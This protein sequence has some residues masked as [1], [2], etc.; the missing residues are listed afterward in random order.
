ML[1]FSDS[2]TEG[3]LIEGLR[4]GDEHVFETLVRTYGGRLLSVAR[5]MLNNEED[6]RDADRKSVV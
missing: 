5:R 2:M 1:R 4:S 3:A 6:A